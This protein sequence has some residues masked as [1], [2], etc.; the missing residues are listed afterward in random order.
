MKQR[1]GI[2]Q[3]TGFIDQLFDI[4]RNG[5]PF[6]NAPRERA[7]F[8]GF[9]DPRGIIQFGADLGQHDRDAGSIVVRSM[10]PSCYGSHTRSQEEGSRVE[11]RAILW[12]YSRR[13][14]HLVTGMPSSG[15]R[16]PKPQN[17]QTCQRLGRS[18][19]NGPKIDR[20]RS[21]PPCLQIS[22]ARATFFGLSG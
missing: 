22:A 16:T 13:L 6:G 12:R 19:I 11:S 8:R 5:H 20:G 10:K 1:G 2:L 21:A 14:E 15:G 7:S 3:T 18:S 9:R 17:L 4:H